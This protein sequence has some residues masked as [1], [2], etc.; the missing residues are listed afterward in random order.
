MKNFTPGKVRLP[1]NQTG[2]DDEADDDAVV[3]VYWLWLFFSGC[4]LIVAGLIGLLAA[5]SMLISCLGCF[6]SAVASNLWSL[7][8]GIL[9]IGAVGLTAVKPSEEFAFLLKPIWQLAL[10]FVSVNH[11]WG[12]SSSLSLH[13]G[14]VKVDPAWAIGAITAAIMDILLAR[15]FVRWCKAPAPS[16]QLF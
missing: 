12:C 3:V 13:V 5:P 7:F 8:F 14:P 11:A 6:S 2:A 16:R 1:P 4:G 15:T 10:I 9:L